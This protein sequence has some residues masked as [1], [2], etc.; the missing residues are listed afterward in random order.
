[1]T[2]RSRSAARITGIGVILPGASGVEEFWQHLRTGTSQFGLLSDRADLSDLPVRVAARLKG[3]DHRKYLPDLRPEYAAKY[4]RETL[5]VMSA[6][7]EARRDAG[8]AREDVDPRRIALIASSS[9]G[10]IES[11]EAGIRDELGA[12]R[13]GPPEGDPML[14]ALP[15]GPASLSAIYNDVQGLVTT[16]S[17]ACVG[18]AHALSLALDVL[19]SGRADAA[20]VV[21]HEFPITRPVILSFLGMGDGVL[22]SEWDDP[23]RA[24]RPYTAERDGF[25]FGEGAV[26]LCLERPSFA[27]ARNA[28][29]YAEIL[30]CAT[31]NEAAH[32]FTLDQTGCFTASVVAEALEEAGRKPADVGYYC[33]HGTGTFYNDLGES[34]AMDVLYPGVP[35]T[36]WPPVGSVKPIYGHLLGGA[37]VLNAAATAL[38]LHRRCLAP[39]INIDVPAPECDHDHVA[40]GARPVAVDLAVSLSFA[41]GSQT[42]AVVLGA[43]S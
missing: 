29:A 5:A 30:G 40:E 15:G 21:G 12:L 35:R 8:L 23:A 43:A 32:P 2:A 20:L 14:R 25:V 22:S 31:R 38:M 26:A 17:S 36:K 34:R 13:S 3:F 16:F 18:G 9:R 19:D 11:V 39:T 10:P 27:E 42:A 37:A 6:I 41:I 24:M 4:S 1:V 7:A 28:R 33:G